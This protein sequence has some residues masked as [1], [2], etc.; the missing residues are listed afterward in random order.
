VKIEGREVEEAE[1]TSFIALTLRL[2]THDKGHY[3]A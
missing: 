1:T 2:F 3:H